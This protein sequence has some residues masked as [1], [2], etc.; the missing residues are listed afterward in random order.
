MREDFWKWQIRTEDDR[1]WDGWMTS[2]T[3]WTW[4]WASSG[5]WWWTGKPGVLQFM[6]SQRVGHNW[7][8]E[9]NWERTQLKIYLKLEFGAYARSNKVAIWLL[10]SVGNCCP[11]AYSDFKAS[12]GLFSWQ[13]REGKKALYFSPLV[14]KAS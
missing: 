3:R 7:V 4:V 1:G 9:L 10:V 12:C 11:F 2:L 8:T 14:V 5:S 6:G 13:G